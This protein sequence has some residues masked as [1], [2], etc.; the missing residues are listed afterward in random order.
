MYRN[1]SWNFLESTIWF[2]ESV[3]SFRHRRDDYSHPISSYNLEQWSK[4]SLPCTRIWQT[5]EA[6]RRPSATLCLLHIRH[7]QLSWFYR[8]LGGSPL[9]NDCQK[10]LGLPA[11]FWIYTRH[12]T[13]WITAYE[14][15]KKIPR[16]FRNRFYPQIQNTCIHRGKL[17]IHDL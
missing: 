17:Y 6:K 12:S 10:D 7:W 14:K 11:Y 1:G 2:N 4:W 15:E 9:R 13:F 5:P 8:W 16:K 3:A